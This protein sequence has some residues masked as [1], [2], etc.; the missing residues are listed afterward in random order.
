MPCPTRAMLSLPALLLVW[1]AP[2]CAGPPYLTD[3]PAPTDEGHFEIYGFADGTTARAGSSGE[4]GIDFNYGGA[5]DLQ[6]TAV[7]PLGWSAPGVGGGTATLG[8]IEL[9]AKY[10][11]LH[12][13]EDGVDVA[14]FPRV[15][16]PAGSPSIGA[17]NT[18]FFLPIWIGRSWGDW[19]TFGGGG[20]SLN[21][22]N[23]MQNFCQYGWVLADQVTPSLQLGAEIYRQTASTIGGRP[24]TYAGVGAIY[25]LNAHYHLMASVGPGLQNAA[26]TSAVDWYVALLTNF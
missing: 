1:S 17:R 11:F 9:A 14:V 26:A 6:L 7:I 10:K 3:D 4:S 16:L 8:N 24:S 18:Q 13:D 20:C 23:G 5:K 21:R 19:S 25:D 12:Q 22:G 15:F 2:A